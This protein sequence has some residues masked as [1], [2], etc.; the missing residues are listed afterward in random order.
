MAELA[1][2]FKIEAKKLCTDFNLIDN[3]WL[4]IATAYQNKKRYYH[5]LSHLENV[6]AELLPLKAHFKDWSTVVFSIFYHDI[7]YSSTKKDNEEQS[8]IIG[9][10]RSL[11]LGVDTTRAKLCKRQIL[12]TKAHEA[13]GNLDT[14]LFTDA[15]LSILG[16]DWTTYQRY[17]KAIR[18]EYKRYPNFFYN[19][20][21]KKALLHFLEMD[22]IFKT[23]YFKQLYEQ[24]ARNNIEQEIKL[25]E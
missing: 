6:F 20:A 16:K 4:E 11:S 15:D 25:L 19:P 8:A 2:I 10:E 18:K 24:Q 22:A 14:D 13:T 7:V 1:S 23:P 9:F 3:L 17:F 5:N 21:R 12:A